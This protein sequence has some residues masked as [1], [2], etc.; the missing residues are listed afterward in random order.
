M[1]VDSNG[2]VALWFQT[3][4]QQ[5][6]F[7]RFLPSLLFSF[8]GGLWITFDF[9]RWGVFWSVYSV[10]S[11]YGGVGGVKMKNMYV[12]DQ[13]LPFCENYTLYTLFRPLGGGVHTV[14]TVHTVFRRVLCH[15]GRFG[16]G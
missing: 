13:N 5:H 16:C 8:V 11:V 7:F 2:W 3:K 4:H 15:L 12:L 10:Y 14:H 1:E 6:W 9:G